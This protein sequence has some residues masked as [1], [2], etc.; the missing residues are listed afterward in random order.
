MICEI[1]KM[2]QAD[3]YYTEIVDGVKNE[4]YICSSCAK[5]LD[6]GQ[7]LNFFDNDKNI[8]E[9]I[10]G[11]FNLDSFSE[12]DNEYKRIICPSCNT[13]YD[14]FIKD[15]RFGCKD[16]YEVFSILISD[17]IRH[18]QGADIHKG[19]KIKSKKSLQN[20]I[21]NMSG[22]EENN[23]DRLQYMLNMAI[24]AEDYSAAAKYRDAIKAIK[25]RE[26]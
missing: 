1:C 13:S 17:N 21:E 9:L 18:L 26:E 23:I 8:K 22:K 12:K 16:C 25:E 4:H 10:S 19:K 20:G 3:I 7:M 15:S 6:F 14:E 24:E 5:D 11:V 2:R